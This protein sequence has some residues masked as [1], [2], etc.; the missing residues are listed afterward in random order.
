[1]PITSIPTDDFI[2]KYVF[3]TDHKVI[4]IQYLVT[5]LIFMMIGGSFAESMRVQLFNAQGHFVSND[6]YNMLY[7]LHGSLMVWMVTI[8]LVTGFFGN[9]VM[10][11][12]IGA[13]DVAFPWLN[14]ISYWTFPVAG[15]LMLSSILYGAPTAGW[16]EYPPISVLGPPGVSWWAAA[17]ALIGVSSTMTALNFTVTIVKM[18]APGMTFT[19]MPLF[20]WAQL[21][22]NM[23]MLIATT[24]LAVAVSALFIERQF[25]VPFFDPARGGSPVMYQHM[26]WFYSHPAVYIIILPAFGIISEVLPTF[27]R[28][29]IFGYKM[30]AF[31]SMAIALA[32]FMVWAHQFFTSGLGRFSSYPS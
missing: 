26:F 32:G 3:S 13:R 20:V 9:Y 10:P 19:R 15:L 11:L 16:A 17:V 14:M 30:I 24:A 21:A 18:R 28:K 29:P 2:R 25:G 12:Q 22:T 23:I 6:V 31:S 5:A 27:A 4:A 1:M 8:P 7:S